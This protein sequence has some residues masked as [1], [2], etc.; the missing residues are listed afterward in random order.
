MISPGGEAGVLEGE[1]AGLDGLLDEIVDQRLELGAGELHG[2]VL[3]PGLVRRDI[4]QVDFGLGGRRQLDLGGFGGLLEALQCQL[5][6]AQVDALLLLEFVGQIVDEPHVEIFAAQERVAVRGLHLEYA[7]A[8]L[9]N[10]NIKGAAAEVIDRDRAGLLLVEPVSE[11]GRGRFIDDAEHFEAGDLAGVLG[12]LA[13]GVVEIRRHGDHRLGDL[14]AE[15]G[16]GGLLHLL[17]HEGGN[18]RRRVSLAVSLDPGVA[19]AGAHDLVGDELLVLLH[20]RVVITPAHQALHGK[21][22]ALRI[23]DRLALGRLA[24]QTLAVIGKRHNRRRGVASFG[25][26]DDFRRLA[27]HY[28]DTGIGRAEV[29][30]NDLAHFANPLLSAGRPGPLWHPKETSHRSRTCARPSLVRPLLALT[31]RPGVVLASYRSLAGGRKARM[32]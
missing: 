11:R 27:I 25:I 17:Q 4:G 29:D 31:R 16:L 13:L 20:H 24:D 10:R 1:P 12:G 19:I 21:E 32:V 8:D 23:G 7:V 26:L 2:E 15:I 18:L 22:S 28:G 6:A 30:A 5:V 14:L 3:R 9:Q